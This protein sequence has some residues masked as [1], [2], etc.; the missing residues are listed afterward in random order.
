MNKVKEVTYNS[1]DV[2]KKLLVISFIFLLLQ[3]FATNILLFIEP[4]LYANFSGYTFR[5]DIIFYLIVMISIFFIVLITYI[6]SVLLK[7]PKEEK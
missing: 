1:R 4:K 2:L 3:I 6:I 7:S 5:E